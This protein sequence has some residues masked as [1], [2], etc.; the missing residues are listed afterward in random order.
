MLFFI[1]LLLSFIL[2]LLKHN[3]NKVLQ[4][5]NTKAFTAYTL[6]KTKQKQQVNKQK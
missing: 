1:L 6:I 4:N 2:S 3:M 5:K